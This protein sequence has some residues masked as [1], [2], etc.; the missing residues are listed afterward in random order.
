MF[1]CEGL[2]VV[3]RMCPLLPGDILFKGTFEFQLKL[4]DVF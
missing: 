2:F 4:F 1:I 3:S